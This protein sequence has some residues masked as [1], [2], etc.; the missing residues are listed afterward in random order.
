MARRYKKKRSHGR[1]KPSVISMVPLLV[2]AKNGYEGYVAG[3]LDS[4]ATYM[5]S[6]AI[7][8]NFGTKKIDFG[9]AGGFYLSL[10]GT[11][12]A[13]KLVGMTGANRALRGL[14]FRL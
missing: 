9:R 10:A 5:A 3:G 11:Y 14:P 7:P 8:Y 2:L 13:K 6:T 12:A 4:A 1:A